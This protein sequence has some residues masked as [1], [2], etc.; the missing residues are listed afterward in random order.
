[1]PNSI[2]DVALRNT[3]PAPLFNLF[4]DGANGD[5]TF[6]GR[7][8][9][10]A[11]KT[12]AGLGTIAEGTSVGLI[13]DGHW[14]E[15]LDLPDGARVGPYGTGA[16]PILDA[17][18]I[19]ANASF[20]K[21]AGRTNVY[22]IEWVHDIGDADGKRKFSVWE[23][24]ARLIRATSEANCDATAGSFYAPDPE[25]ATTQT[26]FV[27]P[28]GS[29]NPT[30]DGKLYEIT[31]REFAVLVGENGIVEDIHGL[32]A[33]HN[34]G[35]IVAYDGA[36]IRRGTAEDG[37]VHN[38]LM[39]SGV[40]EDTILTKIE[41]G[42][43]AGNATMFVAYG[44]AGL[45]ITCRRVRAIGSYPVAAN[46][47]GTVGFYSHASSS[48]AGTLTFED[49]YA[50]N[51]NTAIGGDC[52]SVIVTGLETLD[53][54]NG[55]GATTR[56]LCSV[57][58]CFVGKYT[59]TAKSMTRFVNPGST[60]GLKVIEGNVGIFRETSGG[61]LFAGGSGWTI[62]Y[63]TLKRVGGATGAAI[64]GTSALDSVI[65]HN[66]FDGF[67]TAYR[68]TQAAAAWLS[69]SNVI[70]P[71]TTDIQYRNTTYNDV[72]AYKA[73]TGLDALSSTADPAFTIPDA[74]TWAAI[75]DAAPGGAAAIALQAGATFYS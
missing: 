16:D 72:A 12:I 31:A 64:D 6:N 28:K 2:F 13:R 53:V 75:A 67:A 48:Y 65:E 41:G 14:R 49:C 23:G 18:N 39:G 10:F 59:D 63:N 45:N 54:T 70:Y 66:I 17:S 46:R 74:T 35:V 29:T 60:A 1:M 33:G 71:A 73:A 32:R 38:V 47:T 20:T 37:T 62:R 34:D 25:E 7:S 11:L 43:S 51:V 26:I 57:K 55:V 50:E 4:V 69:N 27:H 40:I 24:G 5:D 19:A 58:E 61:A 30:S 52:D 22:Q 9:A 36:T 3:P 68:S 56:T 15:F 44:D 8:T 21:T 42:P